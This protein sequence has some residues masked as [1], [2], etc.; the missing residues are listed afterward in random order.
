MTRNRRA[1]RTEAT[2]GVAAAVLA[3]ETAGCGGHL[4]VQENQAD[5]G[6]AASGGASSAGAGGA[7]AA[8]GG[9]GNGGGDGGS[10]AATPAASTS[11]AN[12]TASTT[13][14]FEESCLND[15]RDGAETDVDCGGPDCLPCPPAGICDIPGS[16]DSGVCEDGF[17]QPPACDD[18]V[19]NGSETDIDCGGDE[20]A[21][22]PEVCDCA[23]SESLRVIN[24][25]STTITGTS[26]PTPGLLSADGSVMVY[27][28]CIGPD[29]IGG[30]CGEFDVMRQ[31]GS[32][33]PELLGAGIFSEAMTPDGRYLVLT[34]Y[35][36]E[37]MTLITPDGR[38]D[39]DFVG[40][41]AAISDDG[42]VLAVT[43]YPDAEA[44]A[45]RWTREGGFEALGD[46]PEGTGRSRAT[47][48]SADGSVVVGYAQ[49]GT[50]EVPFIWRAGAL[51]ALTD[52]PGDATT[53]WALRVSDD[54]STM[55]GVTAVV[56]SSEF[57]WADVFRW[58]EAEGFSVLGPV[59]GELCPEMLRVRVNEDGSLVAGTLAFDDAGVDRVAFRWTEPEGVYRLM[60]TAE[61]YPSSVHDMSADGAVIV[62]QVSW[63]D[64]SATVWTEAWGIAELGGLL[65]EFGVDTYGW[66]FT[67]ETQV[68]A[69]GKVIVG[70]ASC[71]GTRALY[72]A[73][74]PED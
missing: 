49:L 9:T 10:G 35:E 71:G 44:K 20:C 70:V 50:Q 69:D 30:Q 32:E 24:C 47:D 65:G 40:R 29:P 21:T 51:E 57:R 39:L 3:L 23:E 18:E 11:T 12:T 43:R 34:D 7:S 59:C 66:E 67:G 37:G 73:V 27:T 42:E 54:G 61:P 22:C 53:A 17:C 13:G 36:F 62:G 33:A 58:T 41:A 52:L 16:C 74:L 2:L 56:S 26:W 31:S 15:V 72:R 14:V 38:E 55:V 6:A 45:M 28:R 46:I 63:G 25:G 60:N 64:F 48:M 1:L 5:A 68:S 4:D 8:A 19:L